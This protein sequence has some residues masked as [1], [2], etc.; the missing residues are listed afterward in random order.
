MVLEKLFF[1]IIFSVNYNVGLLFQWLNIVLI[2][3]M[4]FLLVVEINNLSLYQLKVICIL[5][6]SCSMPYF[7]HLL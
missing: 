3:E 7:L 1:L 4:T 2:V 5:W 6:F